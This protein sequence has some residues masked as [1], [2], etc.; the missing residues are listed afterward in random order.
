MIKNLVSLKRQLG[1]DSQD[2][3]QVDGNIDLI[4]V[5]WGTKI[6]PWNG[7][8]SKMAHFFF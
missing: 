3:H 6:L 1:R 5:K 8:G 4:P 7:N 2:P